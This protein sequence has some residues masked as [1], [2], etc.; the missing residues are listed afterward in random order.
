MTAYCLVSEMG[1]EIKIMK[2]VKNIIRTTLLLALAASTTACAQ[3][4]PSSYDQSVD[5][6]H[7]SVDASVNVVADKAL[8]EY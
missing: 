5:Y 7:T 4:A 3:V 1:K 6:S 2:T 8:Y